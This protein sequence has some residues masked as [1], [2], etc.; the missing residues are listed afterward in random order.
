MES[1]FRK[2]IHQLLMSLMPI[3]DTFSVWIPFWLLRPPRPRHRWRLHPHPRRLC[4]WPQQLHRWQVTFL[5]G[6]FRTLLPQQPFY[7]ICH[8]P[9][10]LGLRPL[11]WLPCSMVIRPWGAIYSPH[12]RP[13]KMTGSQTTQKWLWKPKTY[14]H[15][16]TH[17]ALRWWSPNQEGK[18][19]PN[20]FTF[21]FSKYTFLVIWST[22][23]SQ[24]DNQTVYG[25][26]ENEANEM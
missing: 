16:F 9:L 18:L 19:V 4:L 22:M 11:Q 8:H 23:R 26:W 25:F 24:S 6:P 7:N 17:M 10:V 13:L 15:S 21:N 14:G 20:N 2:D 3:F 12:L 1:L 5:R